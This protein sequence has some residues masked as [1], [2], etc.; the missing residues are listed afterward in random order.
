MHICEWVHAL[1]VF[2]K[3]PWNSVKHTC[4][5]DMGRRQ[6]DAFQAFHREYV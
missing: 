6:A 2:F 4:L 5:T 3:A 1:I